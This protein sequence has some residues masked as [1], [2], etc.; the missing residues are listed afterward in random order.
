MAVTAN[1]ETVMIFSMKQGEE[2]IQA[3]IERFKN[4]IEQRATLKN[5]DEWGKRKLAY[6]INKESEGYY[7]LFDF[8]ST[9]EFP[10]ELDRRF[11]IT[12]GVIRSLIIKKEED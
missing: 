10:A 5:V 1:Y 12:E 6:L 7:V 2:G 8:E 3:L 11:R 4:L 9:A